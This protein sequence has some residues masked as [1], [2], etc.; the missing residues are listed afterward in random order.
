MTAFTGVESLNSDPL[1]FQSA[2]LSDDVPLTTS[3][4][5]YGQV[6][7]GIVPQNSES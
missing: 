2:N 5:L 6:K 3:H 1:T 4:F 7:G